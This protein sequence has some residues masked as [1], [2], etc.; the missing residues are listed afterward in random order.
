M[1][2]NRVVNVFS[3]DDWPLDENDPRLGAPS[4][5]TLGCSG[6]RCWG[7]KYWLFLEKNGKITP[8]GFF[9][10]FLKCLS[11]TIDSIR[12]SGRNQTV[13]YYVHIRLQMLQMIRLTLEN[14][15]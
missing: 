1:L 9:E 13:L 14:F 8:T 2:Q 10:E 6:E 12:T 15:Y 3:D 4:D 11:A 7:L 5:D